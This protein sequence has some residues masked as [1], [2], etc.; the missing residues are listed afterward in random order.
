MLMRVVPKCTYL[1]ASRLMIKVKED[2]RLLPS[3]LTIEAIEG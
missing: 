2:T 1:L 3:I